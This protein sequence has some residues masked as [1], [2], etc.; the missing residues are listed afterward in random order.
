MLPNGV[1]LAA[2]A[3]VSPRA[4]F[5]TTFSPETPYPPSQM[6]S[7][8]PPPPVQTTA[9]APA[10]GGVDPFDVQWSRLALTNTGNH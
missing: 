1:N 10:C 9:P 3:Q 4:A 8:A 5:P 6:A 7:P 2:P